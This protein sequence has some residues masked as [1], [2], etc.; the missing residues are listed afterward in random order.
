MAAHR[1][2][3][4]ASAR[5]LAAHRAQFRRRCPPSCGATR[6]AGS[7]ARCPEFHMTML[8]HGLVPFMTRCA[9]PPWLPHVYKKDTPGS[10]DVSFSHHASLRR[11][12][13]HCITGVH[14]AQ[15]VLL[16]SPV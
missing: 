9:F 8:I 16:S 6:R 5:R 4:G 10:P 7:C 14:H 3:F 1:A 11:A 2:Q 15:G 13:R 12:V